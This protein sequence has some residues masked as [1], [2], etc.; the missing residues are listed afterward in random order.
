MSRAPTIPRTPYPRPPAMVPSSLRTLCV[1]IFCLAPLALSAAGC[2]S[3]SASRSPTFEAQ[4]T[5]V[6]FTD[7]RH[8][9]PLVLS[10]V[11]EL[12]TSRVDLYSSV[13]K[14]ASTKVA[15]DEV[16]DALVEYLSQQGFTRHATPGSAGGRASQSL[17]LDLGG[18]RTHM[19]IF[20]GS[21]KREIEAFCACRDGF[22]ELY[23]QIYQLQS[24]DEVPHRFEQQRKQAGG[25]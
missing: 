20:K 17:E 8:A 25:R 22:I 18:R 21:G 4:P 7:N 14:E 10:L 23:N 9:K 24:V 6:T 11:N 2:A 5:A 16:V 15:T 13:R 3:T 19:G 12:H 1:R